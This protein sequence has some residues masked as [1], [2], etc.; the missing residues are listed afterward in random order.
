MKALALSARVA[1]LAAAFL[2]LTAWLT[3]AA[4]AQGNAGAVYTITNQDA[5]NAVAVF[6]RGADGAL[7]SA[8]QYPTGGLGTGGGLGN[9]GALALS[10][11]G[12]FLFVVNPGSDDISSFRIKSGGLTLVDRIGSGGV[13]PISLTTSG[14]LLYVL[15]AG[16][17]AGNISGF[18]VGS[19][20]SLAA[21]AGSTRPL[22]AASVGPAQIQFDPT[23]GTLVVTEKATNLIDT[24]TI[25]ANGIANG[26][27]VQ[28]SS[29]Q[30]P[31]GFAFDKRGH[32]IVSEA[33]GGTASALSSYGI[34]DGGSL[35][36]I[37][38]SVYAASERA[39]CWVVTTGD[40]KFAYTTNTGSGSIS[41]Y[42]IGHDGSLSLLDSDGLTA[43]T[44]GAPI[45]AALSRNDQFLYALNAITLRIDAF[46]VG[47]DGSLTA[48]PSAGIGGFPAGVNGL[49]AT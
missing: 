25:G 27:S 29:G 39:A 19:D 42:A 6:D 7:T 14:D 13:I 33:F 31:F 45:D 32:L 21:I 28:T 2:A 38:P 43:V 34:G 35:D 46:R 47:A 10:N 9:Q 5:G 36:V 18:R 3:G 22:S 20:G 11:G 1:V 16:G 24:Y 48:L 8:G 44:G 17:S 15:N 41:G 30:T 40:G 12:R 26:P 23:A 49:V 4:T 37:S